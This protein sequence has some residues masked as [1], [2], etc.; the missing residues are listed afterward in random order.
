MKRFVVMLSAL[1]LLCSCVTSS[2][3][4]NISARKIPPS[5]HEAL[6]DRYIELSRINE[7]L[8]AIPSQL[9]ASSSI[10]GMVAKDP[11]SVKKIT[12]I[13]KESFDVRKVEKTLRSFLLENT[14][15][16]FLKDMMKWMESP[17]AKRIGEA[18]LSASEPG[19]QAKML[20]YLA[21]LQTDPPSE[22]RIAVIR[23]VEEATRTSELAGKIVT[24]MMDAMLKW[25]EAALTEERRN[26][27]GNME[28]RMELVKSAIQEQ[29][30]QGI[31]LSTFYSYRN[32]SNQDLI[33]Y[34]EFYRSVTGMA[35][36]EIAE[37][38]LTHILKEWFE[39]IGEKVI[40]LIKEEKGS[41][42]AST[43][44]KPGKKRGSGRVG[45]VSG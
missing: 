8:A 13:M 33:Q 22:E 12:A 40:L 11:D 39:D 35:D 34:T 23:E 44:K 41:S 3:K 19:A 6:V 37:K 26:E 9:D 27:M 5:S 42:P 38:L 30:R 29:M 17:S 1:T 2:P 14:D 28:E 31:I 43:P 4:K 21:D 24:E 32:I 10:Q 36:L 45:P 16:E 7:A 15:V 25:G 18:V 20:R